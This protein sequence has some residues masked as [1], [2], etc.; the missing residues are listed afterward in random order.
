MRQ[1]VAADRVAVAIATEDED[2]EIG[3]GKRDA[4]GEW[5]GAAVDEVDAVGVDEI[6]ETRGAADAGD[7]DDFLVGQAELLDDVE[8]GGEDGEVTAGRAPGRVVGF[9]LFFCER[10]GGCAHGLKS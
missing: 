7:A 10:F 1:V 9:E 4:G 8:E 5:Q 6:G 2:V 3:T